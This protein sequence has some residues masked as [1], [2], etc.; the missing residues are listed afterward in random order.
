MVSER[1]KT[2]LPGHREGIHMMEKKPLLG[3]FDEQWNLI[4]PPEIQDIL[5]YGTIEITVEGDCIVLSRA[6]PIY[7][8][9]W[10]PKQNRK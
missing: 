2:L 5:G 9:V 6:E 1:H 7:R 8:C 4:L 3:R 10:E